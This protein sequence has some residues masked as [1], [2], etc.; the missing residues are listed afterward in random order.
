MKCLF[1]ILSLLMTG[2]R[3]VNYSAADGMPS[4]TVYA[5]AQD[6]GGTLWI[7][8]RNGLASYDGTGFRSW[9]DYGR[10][11]ALTVDRQNR[12]WVGTTE[13]LRVEDDGIAGNIRALTTDSDGYVWATVGDTLLLKLSFKDGIREEARC[14]YDKRDSE[15]DYPYYQIYEASDGKLWLAGR[16]VHYQFI[17][18]REKPQITHPLGHD[19]LCP[20]SY[21]EAGGKLYYFVDH[22]SILY[23]YEDNKAIAHGRL[24]IAHARLLTDNKGRNK[25][26]YSATRQTIRPVCLP[27][28][29]TAYSKTSRAISGQVATTASPC[30]LLLC[31]R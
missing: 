1:L 17:G 8:T 18:D 19:G 14:F 12:L 5:I 27:A 7:G 20:G 10:V 15:G 13:G 3:F 22:T 30:F 6:S 24:P 16:L 28:N 29:S 31:S 9:K 21:A 11:N 26:R 25:L 2:P 4:N 23:S